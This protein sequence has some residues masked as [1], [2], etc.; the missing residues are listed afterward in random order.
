MR[1]NQDSGLKHARKRPATYFF[2]MLIFLDR[3]HL[4]Q[5]VRR[6]RDGVPR[7]NNRYLEHRVQQYLH[8]AVQP[9]VHDQ[10]Q[11]RGWDRPKLPVQ[12]LH[13]PL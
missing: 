3:K 10:I 13:W 12:Q 2:C 8:L 11:W 9:D 4:L 5:L 1:D 7:Y 6:L